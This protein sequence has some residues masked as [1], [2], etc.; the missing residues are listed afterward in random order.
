DDFFQ[1]DDSLSRAHDGA[2]LGL[3]ICRDLVKLMDGSIEVESV[4][5]EGSTFIV[6]LPLS[7]ARPAAEAPARDGDPSDP[8]PPLRVLAAEDNATN[9]LVLK[10]LLAQAGVEPTIVENGR[11]A[12]AA[13]E[14]QDWDLI[15]MD[16]R[17][18]EMDGIAAT[19][20]IRQ[21]ER[22]TGRPLTPIIAVT[23]NAMAHQLEE[24]LAAGMERVVP[25]PIDAM[26][27]FNAM[28][29]ALAMAEVAEGGWAATG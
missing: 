25:K 23:A 20:A 15:L 11:E 6:R 17:M 3:A 22:E 9:Q 8:A 26:K 16:I 2:G 4:F 13:W 1:A 7:P 12:V 24:Y 10:T 5:G 18:P 28:E 29:E 14:T 21:R 19:R 27:L